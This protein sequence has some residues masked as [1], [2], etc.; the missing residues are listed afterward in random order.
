MESNVRVRFAPSPTGPLHIGGVRTALY[1][2]LFAKKHKG[3][4]ILR[5]EDTDQTRY[6][7]NAEQYIIDA[8]KWCNIPYDEGPG[9]N[10]KFGPYRQSERKSLY[11]KYADILLEKG[12]AYYAFDTP[13]ELTVQRKLYE[14]KGKMF[15]YNWH[16][17]EDGKLVNS[18]VL[19]EEEVQQRI[20]AGDKYVIRFKSPKSEI[21]F[22]EDEIRGRITIKTNTLDDKVLF[23]SDGMPTYHLANIVDDHL[24]EIT[25]V[26]RGEEWLPSMPLHVLLYK[27]FDWEIPK[28]AHLPLILKPIGRGKLSKRDGDKLGFP[29]FPL[30]YKNEETGEISR[31]FKEDG[32]FAD[33]F[34]N[35]L[36]FLGWNPG[37]TQEIFSLDKLV[38]KFDF[39]R[40]NKAGAK[41]D[42]DKTKWFQQQYMQTKDNAELTDL[43]MPILADKGI[44]KEKEA[45]KNIVSS[46]K[47]RA[48]FVKDLWPLATYFFETPQI[49]DAKAIKKVWKEDTTVLMVELVDALKK[50][51]DFSSTN[52]EKEIKEWITGKGISYGKIMQPLRLCLVGKLA[53]PHLFDIIYLIGKTETIKRIEN[54]IENI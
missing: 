46:V 38:E 53:G 17:R 22:M 51:E 20:N 7:A 27:A 16:N 31:G 3:T 29:V 19:S 32:Y 54:A 26:I 35:M 40:V 47:E 33:A 42:L 6:V 10:E 34:I 9:K 1:N 4:F 41:F 23:K 49:Y 8:L 30:A 37:T 50:I 39:E 14:S 18:L 5:I 15:I 45:I 24:M 48:V 43:F 12:A 44:N 13:E 21:L 2:Y 11:K 36:A 52:N 25:H 28:F